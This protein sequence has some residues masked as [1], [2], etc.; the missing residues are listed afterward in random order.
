MRRIFA[1]A[2]S[3]VKVQGVGYKAG[4]PRVE[5]DAI[6]PIPSDYVGALRLALDYLCIGTARAT[7]GGDVTSTCPDGLTCIE[8]SCRPSKVPPSVVPAEKPVDGGAA[9]CFDVAACF[10]TAQPAS[11]DP[12]DCTLALPAGIDPSTINVALEYAPGTGGG[13]CTASGCWVVFDR[14]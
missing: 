9:G 12:T 6:T 3:P 10:G 1:L 14:G 4:E 5:R 7:A 13:V 11:V 2:A 8:G